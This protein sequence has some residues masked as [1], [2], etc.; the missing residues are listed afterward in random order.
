MRVLVLGGDG[1]LGWATAMHLSARQH[2][3]MVA[4]NYLRRDA[5]REINVEP[6][7]APPN[8]AQRAAIWRS[9]SGGDIKVR[10]GDVADYSFLSAI[11]REFEP[12]GIVHYAEQPSAPYSMIDQ[13]HAA[14]TI[15]NNLMATTNVVFAVR[16]IVPGSHIVKLGTMGE[17]GT[18]NIDIEE[19]YLNVTHNGRSHKF[20]YPKTPGSIYHLT[21]VQD[22]DL[23]Y[24]ATRVWGLAVTDLNQGPV[25]GI[26][27]DELSA[28]PRLAPIFNYDD[29]FGT[30]IN[31]FLVQA[32]AGFPLTVYGK[33]GQVRGYLNIRD[34]LQCVEL[35]LTKPASRGEFRVFNQFVET[36]SVNQIAARVAAVGNRLGLNVTVQP[37][38][39]PRKEAE[40]HYYNPRNTGLLELGLNPHPLTD[41]ILS[42]MLEYVRRHANRIN[43]DHI[44]PKVKW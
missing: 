17:Y 37:I 5:C 4:D 11:V 43:R 1:Y 9:A 19:G 26:E 25:Y 6:L 3:V 2:D 10:I 21:K 42:G 16:D 22:S 30:V 32:I 41:D 27:T 31:R 39:N 35:A 15:Q 12:E 8:L 7:I 28:D 20:L 36:F 24:F 33:G 13:S 14:R 38:A 18:P 44:L 34:T 23:M 29:V 40:E